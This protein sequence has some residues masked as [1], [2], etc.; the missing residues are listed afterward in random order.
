LQDLIDNFLDK[1]RSLFQQGRYINIRYFK[2]L[3]AIGESMESAAFENQ[4]KNKEQGSANSSNLLSLIALCHDAHQE[5]LLEEE[6]SLQVIIL[7]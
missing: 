5:H 3:S 2:S 4:V 6:A 1:V 7:N